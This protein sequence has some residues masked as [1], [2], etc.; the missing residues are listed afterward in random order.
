MTAHFSSYVSLFMF[1]NFKTTFNATQQARSPITLTQVAPISHSVLI[2][3]YTPITPAGSPAIVASAAKEAIAH[4]EHQE[5][6]LRG[7]HLPGE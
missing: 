1:V 4:Q 5:F 3:I 2:L 6:Q 7:A